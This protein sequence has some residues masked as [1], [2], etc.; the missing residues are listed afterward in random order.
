MR[1]V[2]G[3]VVLITGAARGIGAQTARELAGRG[4][5]LA[6]VGLE[7]DALAEVAAELGVGHYWAEA[8]V[9]DPESIGAAVAGAVEELGGIDACV[10]NAGIA[11]VG[12]IREGD[13]RGFTTLILPVL[14][15]VLVLRQSA[16]RYFHAIGQDRP[17][18]KAT[19]N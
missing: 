2:A 3:K 4:A 5:K 1:S 19:P 8:D 12:T 16:R 15:L 9:T 17:A 18:R 10:A 11:P 6:L 14:M 7:P 13:P